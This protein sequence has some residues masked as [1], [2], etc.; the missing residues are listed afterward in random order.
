MT[1]L[2]LPVQLGQYP[3]DGTGDDLRTAFTRVNNSFGQII[4]DGAVTNAANVGSGTGIFSTRSG[5][6]IDLK[7]LTSTGNT[8][9][10]TN[11]ANTVNLESVTVLQHD[12]APT[13]GANL[14]LNGHNITGTGC[15]LY[16]SPSPRD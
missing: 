6:I 16:T 9:T 4:N 7:S 2:T 14:S 3:N 1:T 11:T 12:S 13:L 10:I 5:N 15:L 8:V